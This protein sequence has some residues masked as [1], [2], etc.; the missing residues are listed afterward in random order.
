MRNKNYYWFW[1]ILQK[2]FVYK[3]L[4]NRPEMNSVRKW[5]RKFDDMISVERKSSQQN[6]DYQYE[7]EYS[8]GETW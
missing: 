2:D 5:T 3:Y 8:A 7:Q 6:K 4:T 1:K